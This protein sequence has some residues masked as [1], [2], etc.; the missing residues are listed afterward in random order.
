MT[1]VTLKNSVSEE[2]QI[3]RKMVFK[4]PERKFNVQIFDDG[5]MLNVVE[6]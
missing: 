5:E 1:S 3:F 2:R 6:Y 4:F